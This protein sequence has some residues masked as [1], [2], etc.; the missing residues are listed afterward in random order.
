MGN[1]S[2]LIN[3]PNGPSS[4]WRQVAVLIPWLTYRACLPWMGTEHPW[5]RRRYTLAEFAEG[6]TP[7]LMQWGW[8]FWVLHIELIVLALIMLHRYHK[9]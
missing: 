3:G 8:Y 5:K 1:N 9:I 7:L 2:E 4:F 6:A